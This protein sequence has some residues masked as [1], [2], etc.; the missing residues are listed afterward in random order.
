MLNLNELAA[1]IDE[2]D[3]KSADMVMP[4]AYKS[5]IETHSLFANHLI[6]SQFAS[7]AE[8]HVRAAES[9]LH[10]AIAVNEMQSPRA[11]NIKN[12]QALSLSA[13]AYATHSANVYKIG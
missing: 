12:S 3:R 13:A 8:P 2:I 6:G 11:L 1:L 10:L 4:S 7:V 9:W 5:A